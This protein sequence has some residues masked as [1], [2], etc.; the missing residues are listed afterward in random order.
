MV[1]VEVPGRRPAG[2]LEADVLAALW[3]APGPLSVGQVQE[4][5]GRELAHTTVQTILVRLQAKRAVEREWD[6]RRYW[7]RPVL[8]E[9]D[10]TARQ[11]RRLLDGEGDRAGVLQRFV[12]EL[13]P[14]DEAVLE[15]ALSRARDR[16]R[17]QKG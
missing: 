4:L 5:L 9:S 10:L 13:D 16:R 6:G 14:G 12:S 17:G 3:A 15:A 2:E 11:M 1:A 8:A 7:Y